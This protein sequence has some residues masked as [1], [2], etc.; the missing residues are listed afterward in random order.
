MTFG[1]RVEIIDEYKKWLYI[2]NQ[3][4]I[5]QGQTWKIKDDYLT[6]LGW[7]A[8]KGMLKTSNCSDCI[9]DGT[10]ACPRGAGRAVDDEIC[11]EFI[12]E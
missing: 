10:D 11:E 3:E 2:T 6:F 9:I 4:N 12:N 8:N 1:Q 7:L 5:K